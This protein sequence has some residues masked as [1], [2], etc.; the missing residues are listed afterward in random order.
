MQGANHLNYLPLAPPSFSILAAL[1]VVLVVFVVIRILRYAYVRVGVN[2]R[3]VLLLL[4]ASL[5]GSYINIP[6]AQLPERQ[7]IA[8]HVID[9]Y[10]MQ[11]VIPM[12]ME[13]PGT[14]IAVN[15]GGAIVPMLLSLYLLFWNRIWLSGLVASPR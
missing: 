9:F 1:F 10:G 12:A 5:L 4:L 11:Y 6:I 14:V 15:V 3:L 7:I 8:G 13:R 2:S